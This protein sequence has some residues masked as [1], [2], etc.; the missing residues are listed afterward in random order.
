MTT[1][2]AKR[3]NSASTTWT[4]PPRRCRSS[5][6]TCNYNTIVKKDQVCAKIDPRPY[7]TVVDQNRAN[8]TA[9]KAQVEKSKVSLNYA[10]LTY[11]RMARLGQTNA[12]SKDAVDNAKNL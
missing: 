4:W 1:C 6:A 9:A 5:S 11:D 8:L 12:V 10:H 7:Q 2:C 3:A